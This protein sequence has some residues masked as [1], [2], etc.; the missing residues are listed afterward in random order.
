MEIKQLQRNTLQSKH[1]PSPSRQNPQ[2]KPKAQHTPGNNLA[3]IGP[4]GS[5]KAE[6]TPLHPLGWKEPL[7][8]PKGAGRC[9]EVDALFYGGARFQSLSLPLCS[10]S[11][12][13]SL[14]DPSLV[15]WGAAALGW[16][17]SCTPSPCVKQLAPLVLT[18]ASSP[19]HSLKAGM[20][21][22]LSCF[23]SQ[24]CSHPSNTRSV[25]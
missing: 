5:R 24:L 18:G 25:R 15:R 12:L 2:K 17:H 11:D 16:P 22:H 4:L 21:L 8:T 7:A 10:Q 9:R 13:D 23:C 1:H 19:F 20:W 3:K 6:P 14:R